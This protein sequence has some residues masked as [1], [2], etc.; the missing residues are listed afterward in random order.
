MM[1]PQQT[2]AFESR[3]TIHICNVLPGLMAVKATTTMKVFAKIADTATE[4]TTPKIICL[5]T[6]VTVLGWPMNINEQKKQSIR[7]TRRT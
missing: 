3:V 2:I 1:E 6:Q 4:N 7:E 5:K